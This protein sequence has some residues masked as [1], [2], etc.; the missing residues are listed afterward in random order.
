M[1]AQYRIHILGIPHTATHRDYVACA[2]TQKVHKFLK[3]MSGRGHTIF[4]YGHESRDWDYPD[5]VHVD[6]T[7]DHVLRAAYGVDYVDQQA[8]RQKGFAHYFRVED[9]AYAV[10]H[11]HAIKEI[12]L[13]KQ[14]LDILLCPFGWGHKAIADAHPDLIAM[15]S[16]IGYGSTCLRWKIYES[17]TIRTAAGGLDAVNQ[18]NQDIYSVVI[19][20][21]FDLA[22]FTYQT[23]KSNYILYLGR[24]YS[25]KGVDIAIEATEKAGKQLIIAGQGS[26]A[27]MG[28]TKTPDHVREVGYAD[29]D[30]RRFLMSNASALF[31]ASRYGEPFGGVQIEAMLSGTPV[32]SPDYAAF[33]EFNRDNLTGIRCRTLRDYVEA[34]DTVQYLNPIQC[35]KYA[36]QFSLDVIAPEYERYF[37]DVLAVYTGRGWYEL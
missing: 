35:R 30:L 1:T 10:F 20:N 16:G 32:I 31:I 15:E 8:W 24:I 17:H 13:R 23:A 14:P 5:V 2:F 12:G 4:H 11:A 7:N 6:V 29:A 26:L 9:A 34:C 27:E 28:Y 22:D 18:C 25:G 37:R 36:E 19:P 21:Y 33:A 3:M